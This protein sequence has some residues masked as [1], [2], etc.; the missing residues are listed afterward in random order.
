[1]SL[2]LGFIQKKIANKRMTPIVL[3]SFLI[4]IFTGL[5][6]MN[7]F[8]EIR[9]VRTIHFDPEAVVAGSQVGFSV[10]RSDVFIIGD[11]FFPMPGITTNREYATYLLEDDDFAVVMLVQWRLR[12]EIDLSAGAIRVRVDTQ[13][14]RF[15]QD[16]IDYIEWSNLGAHLAIKDLR[17]RGKPI[18]VYMYMVMQQPTFIH[19][20]WYAI[21]LLLF[22]SILSLIY[23]RPLQKVSKIGKK[24][25]ALGNFEEVAYQVNKQVG[26]AI[27]AKD[28]VWVLSDFLILD[29]SDFVIL[30]LRE[31]T[32][33]N[34]DPDDD[35]P[36]EI[37]HITI[38]CG[39]QTYQFTVYDEADEQQ[40][41]EHIKSKIIYS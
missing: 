33:I 11:M 19:N 30:P 13:Y 20:Y 28:S 26:S 39:E 21:A 16:I 15:H 17:D 27:F 32:H 40:V 23:L 6:L 3:L 24:I 12:D 14:A 5:R 25:A 1:M 41:V 22:A 7:F 10:T 2:K 8:G 18:Y 35:Y 38:Q 4:L 31:I 37:F 36:D 34:S 9:N 29:Q